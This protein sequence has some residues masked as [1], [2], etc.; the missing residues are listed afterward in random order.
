MYTL[1]NIIH[2]FQK[3]NNNSLSHQIKKGGKEER[4]RLIFPFIDSNIVNGFSTTNTAEIMELAKN[5]STTRV[6]NFI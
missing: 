5:C 4:T 6:A 2:D 1:I 3:F